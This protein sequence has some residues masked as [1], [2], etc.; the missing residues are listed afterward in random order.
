MLTDRLRAARPETE[1][2]LISG[3]SED[4]IARGKALDDYVTFLAT[5]FNFGSVG[6]QGARNPQRQ[7]QPAGHGVALR[8]PG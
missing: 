3:Y 5:P 2:L 1:V 8:T 7:R 4:A 6:N